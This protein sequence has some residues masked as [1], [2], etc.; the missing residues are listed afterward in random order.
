MVTICIM[1]I[2]PRYKDNNIKTWFESK[3]QLFFHRRIMRTT[4]LEA[5]PCLGTCCLWLDSKWSHAVEPGLHPRHVYWAQVP[6]QHQR[7]QSR[8]QDTVSRK[9]RRRRLG[10]FTCACQG[11]PKA[12]FFFIRSASQGSLRRVAS[13]SVCPSV[14]TSMWLAAE[15][16]KDNFTEQIFRHDPHK[17]VYHWHVFTSMSIG[18]LFVSLSPQVAILVLNT[19]QLALGTKMADIYIINIYHCTTANTEHFISLMTRF[20]LIDWI[21]FIH[22]HTWYVMKCSMVK[23]S[24]CHI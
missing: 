7:L 14:P 24:S 20:H 3:E 12:G 18:Q 5:E 23:A 13:P 17:A 11:S 16:T 10:V 2:I 15:L 1:S 19:T 6:P 22:V 21:V 4:R 8:T 9:H